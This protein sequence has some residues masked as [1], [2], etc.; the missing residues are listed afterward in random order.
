VGAVTQ[1][2]SI[3]TSGTNAI[4]IRGIFPR[5]AETG[6]TGIFRRH[7][8]PDESRRIQSETTTLPKKFVDSSGGGWTMLRGPQGTYLV[9]VPK[10]NRRATS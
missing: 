1:G 2:V 4:S 3:D 5:P 8:H 7:A 10:R 6:T 9:P